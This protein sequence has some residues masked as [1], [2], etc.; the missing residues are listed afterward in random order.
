MIYSVYEQLQQNL[1]NLINRRHDAPNNLKMDLQ[2]TLNKIKSIEQQLNLSVEY[3]EKQFDTLRSW[4]PSTNRQSVEIPFTFR[5]RT[6][7]GT[8][9]YTPTTSLPDIRRVAPQQSVEKQNKK[10]FGFGG[11]TTTSSKR[12]KKASTKKTDK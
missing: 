3:F 12:A 11:T 2:N 7:N 10:W 6:G 1:N 8:I 9:V 5:A 4:Q